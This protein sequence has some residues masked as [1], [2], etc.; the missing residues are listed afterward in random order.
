M[1]FQ[2]IPEEERRELD[3]ELQNSI[4][5]MRLDAPFFTHLVTGARIKFLTLPP[6]MVALS[7]GKRTIIIDPAKFRKMQSGPRLTTLA[8]ETLHHALRHI[9]RGKG[10]DRAKWY[11]A[12]DVT[13]NSLLDMGNLLYTPPEPAFTAKW[14]VSLGIQIPEEKIQKMS[15]EALY[16]VLPPIPSVQVPCFDYDSE[17]DGDEDDEDEGDKGDKDDE[18]AGKEGGKKEGDAEDYWRER[19][20][21][22]AVIAKQAGKLPGGL[23]WFVK[24]HLKVETPWWAIL[25]GAFNNGYNIRSTWKKPSRRYGDASPG[26]SY[27]GPSVLVLVDSS[28]SITEEEQKAFTGHLDRI[29]RDTNGEI[30]YLMWDAAAYKMLPYRHG[31]KVRFSGGGGTTIQ[32]VL[33]SAKKL[34]NRFDALVVLTDFYISDADDDVTKNLFK[35]LVQRYDICALASVGAQAELPSGWRVLDIR[36]SLKE[37]MR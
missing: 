34:A 29:V 5:A 7:R 26:T 35:E 28:G 6:N 25:Q 22:A 14:A 10:K 18:G 27:R 1:Y 16:E 9:A 4:A 31:Q 12:T 36:N 30:S 17:D 24:E 19:V 33:Q 37:G 15:A 3:R 21:A 32:P 13:V 20:A 23:E 8:H 11:A 2:E